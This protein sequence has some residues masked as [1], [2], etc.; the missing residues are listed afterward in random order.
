MEKENENYSE[1]DLRRLG[2]YFK[3]IEFLELMNNLYYGFIVLILLGTIIGMFNLPYGY[4]WIGLVLLIFGVIQS[5]LLLNLIALNN[6][7]LE[8]RT[9]SNNIDL[10]SK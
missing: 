5:L 4:K 10:L 1:Y 3:S 2:V 7:V 6:N 8:N 9:N